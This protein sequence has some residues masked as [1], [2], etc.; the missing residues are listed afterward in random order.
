MLIVNADKAANHDTSSEVKFI[1]DV[2]LVQTIIDLASTLCRI[3][4]P[5]YSVFK[6][7]D[8][9]EQLKLDLHA[10]MDE[11]KRTTDS[12]YEDYYFMTYYHSVQLWT[13]NEY[14]S[15]KDTST[16]T[17]IYPILNIF[18]QKVTSSRLLPLDRSYY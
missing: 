7:K 5:K 17:K 4:H 12:L 10:D 11:W 16:G 6:A 9:L 8:N 13:L 14:F 2:D 1:Q 15:G 3:G 18:S